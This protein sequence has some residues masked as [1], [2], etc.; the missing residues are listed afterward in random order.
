MNRNMEQIDA[1]F[2]N[3]IANKFFCCFD[4]KF[5]SVTDVMLK[6]S[7]LKCLTDFHQLPKLHEIQ[8]NFEKNNALFE[9]DF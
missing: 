1:N 8:T 4:F 6:I 7:E 3:K 5:T 2:L 9:N